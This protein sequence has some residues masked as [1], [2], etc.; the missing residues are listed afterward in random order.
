MFSVICLHLYTLLLSLI[1]Y[2]LLALVSLVQKLCRY[3]TFSI[4]LWS[5]SPR[6]LILLAYIYA[7]YI[8]VSSLFSLLLSGRGV[9]LFSLFLYCFV[10]TS[11]SYFFIHYSIQL[12]FTLLIG[13]SFVL[14]YFYLLFIL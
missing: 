6:A 3:W 14:Y 2:I 10:C 7:V 13:L 8:L 11:T 1:T 12:S 5:C 9:I 4:I